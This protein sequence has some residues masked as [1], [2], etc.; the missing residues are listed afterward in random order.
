[1]AT[2]YRK[3]KVRRDTAAN[4]AG[5]VLTT[6]EPGYE[7]DTGLF[8]IGNGTDDVGGDLLAING[9]LIVDSLWQMATAK[10]LGRISS[11][12]GGIEELDYVPATLGGTG[13]A[14][15]YTKGDILVASDASTLTKLAIGANGKILRAA[16]GETTGV[17]W[18]T[19][20]TGF[21]NPMSGIGSLIIGGTGGTPQDLPVESTDIDGYVLTLV[22]GVPAWAA[23]TGGSGLPAVE[24]DDIAGYVLKLDS[25]LDPEWAPDETGS[26][27]PDVQSDDLAGYVL[28]LD[29]DLNPVWEP[30]ETSGPEIHHFT[31]AFNPKAVCDGTIDRLFLM[32]V[33]PDF[34][35]GLK[36]TRW[37]CSFDA[38]PTTEAD[39][40]FK[41]ADAFIGVAN[42]A[43]VDVLDTTSGASSETTEANIN[44]NA[45]VANGKVLYLE[46]GTAYTTD[47]LQMIFEFWGYAL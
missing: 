10:I 18:D 37:N 23:P 45:A 5:V 4:F 13:Y 7:T 16:S 36:I 1:M 31:W 9:G 21:N 47:S 12:T 43:V 44:G 40:D 38:D 6:G 28:M 35:N 25:N 41:R 15:G 29:S 46:F 20:T 8:Y 33:G 34:L 11:A 24:S 14:G 22:F 42:A 32:T 27:L 19:E 26:G 39:L 2:V 17:K 30:P 3:I